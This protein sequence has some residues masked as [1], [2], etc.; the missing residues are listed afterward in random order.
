MG[1]TATNDV[2]A[3]GLADTGLRVCGLWRYPVKS[4]AGQELDRVEIGQFGIA[5]DR[6]WGLVDL[7]TGLVLTARRVPDLL[8]ARVVDHGVTGRVRLELPD[9][10]VTDDDEVLSAWLGRPVELRRAGA[11]DVGRYEIAVDDDDPSS[12]WIRWEGPRGVF[13]DSTRTR[14]SILS[15]DALGEWDVRRFRGNIVVTGGDERSLVGQV[16]RIC[17]VEL[18]VVKEIDRCVV[19]TRP[20][21]GLDRDADVLKRVHRERG[22]H[23]GV[24]ALVRRAGAIEL[25]DA[26]RLLV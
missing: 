6:A 5:G 21:P 23:L 18:D 24:G 4:L 17:D 14:V 16:I 1:D 22:G 12:D 26:V 2:G 19:V 25:G 13:H 7:G 20:Q 11:Q 10:T 8:F 15:A 9:G 3:A